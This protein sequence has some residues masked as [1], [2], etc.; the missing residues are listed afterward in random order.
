M[1]GAPAARF[2][3]ELVTLPSF[4]ELFIGAE[5]IFF[6]VCC[7]WSINSLCFSWATCDWV[8]L[9]RS[10]RIII[11]SIWQ[12]RLAVLTGPPVSITQ[13]DSRCRS[14]HRRLASFHPKI[15][16]A[17]RCQ[18]SAKSIEVNSHFVQTGVFAT[19]SLIL[20]VIAKDARQY[21]TAFNLAAQKPL[22]CFFPTLTW[23][24]SFIS[25]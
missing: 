7:S 13:S 11:D 16:F 25:G 20:P 1:S 14:S 8:S 10:V 19:P 22:Y 18:K 23:P 4:Y 9:S 21:E 24:C 17:S 3:W 2:F 15:R 12:M 5:W 6:W